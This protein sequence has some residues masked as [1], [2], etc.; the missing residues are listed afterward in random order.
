MRLLAQAAAAA[1]LAFPVLAQTPPS[2]ASTQ[3]VGV[4]RPQRLRVPLPERFAEA[5]VTKDG[6]LT[7]AQAG[8]S[9]WSYV[10]RNFDAI[11]KDRKGY[12]TVEDIRGHAREMRELRRA[13]LQAAPSKS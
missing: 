10:S 11:D 12:V 1:L 13:A 8:A 2:P 3:P 4:T 9:K 6:H 5:N 7:K